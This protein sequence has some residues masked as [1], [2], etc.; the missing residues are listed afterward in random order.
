MLGSTNDSHMLHHSSLYSLAMQNT[1]FDEQQSMQGFSPFFIGDLD[2]PLLPWLMVPHHAGGQLSVAERLF[3][4]RLRRYR[5]VVENAFGILK[6][7][8]REFLTKSK[9]HVAFYRK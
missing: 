4:K 1:L 8:F 2:Y 7:T 6:S 9:L 5:C 3:N